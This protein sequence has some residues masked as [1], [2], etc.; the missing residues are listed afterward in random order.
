MGNKIRQQLIF[1]GRVQG[2]GFRYTIRHVAN[3]LSLTGWVYNKDDG[4]VLV[5][6]QGSPTLLEKMIQIVSEGRFIEIEH[7]EKK[8]IPLVEHETSFDIKDYL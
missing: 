4:S 1:S 2:V 3:M 7:I 6:V 5:E 8:E